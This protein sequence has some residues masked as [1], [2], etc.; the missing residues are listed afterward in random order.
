MGA[1]PIQSNPGGASEELI[2]NGKNGFLISDINDSEE[3]AALI[4]RSLNDDAL[5]NSAFQTNQGLKMK[6]DFDILKKQVIVKYNSI[7]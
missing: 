4:L 1:F 7:R 2:E 5:L 3:I 6:F